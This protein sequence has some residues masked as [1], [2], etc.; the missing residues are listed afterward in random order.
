MKSAFHPIATEQRTQFYVGLVPSGIRL[1]CAKQN[2]GA[3]HRL[4]NPSRHAPANAIDGR[5]N[6]LRMLQQYPSAP[7]H[8]YDTYSPRDDPTGRDDFLKQHEDCKSGD[9]EQIHYA[10]H[11]QKHHQP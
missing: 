8:E 5:L 2:P 10:T 3:G 6:F 1:L 9:P 7:G 11:K 4:F